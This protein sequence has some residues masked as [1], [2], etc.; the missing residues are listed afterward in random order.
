MRVHEAVAPFSGVWTLDPETCA[1][2]DQRPPKAGVYTILADAQ[3]L[4][5]HVRWIDA[6]DLV[7]QASFRGRIDATLPVDPDH[8]EVGMRTYLEP[9]TLV[10]EVSR[11]GVTL[12]S[13]R[14]RLLDADQMRVTQAILTEAGPVETVAVYRR[15]QTKQVLV[16]RRDLAMRKGK[17][18]AQCA[19]A[20]MAVF[21]RRD[22]GPTDRVIVPLDGPMAAW[23]KGRFAKV[24]LSVETEQDL[25]R[26]AELAEARGLPCALI[27]DAGKTEFK[28]QPTR[29]TVAVGPAAELEIDAITGPAGLVK[30]KLA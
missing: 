12:H 14:R 23:A 1:Y 27:T 17:I 20:S 28:G 24:V 11:E 29:T 18:A 22:E 7:R 15:A 3:G 26:I 4:W 13:A 30:T 2:G 21:F 10:T 5:F 8:P 16:Y 9:D 19:H 6:E 25:L